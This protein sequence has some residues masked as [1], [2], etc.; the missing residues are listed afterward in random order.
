MK[1]LRPVLVV[2]IVI[3]F[4]TW[5]PSHMYDPHLSPNFKFLLST[6]CWMS[7]VLGIVLVARMIIKKIH[8]IE[9]RD[10][11]P[12]HRKASNRRQSFR[13]V[14]PE[15]MRP[16]FIVE[17]S[18]G[19]LRRQLEFPVVDLSEDGIRFIDDGSLGEVNSLIGRLRFQNGVVKKVAGNIVRRMDR[20]TCMCLQ[21]GLDWAT[22]LEEQR[23]VIR[24]LNDASN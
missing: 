7:G 3:W 12:T 10:T 6:L 5:L 22:I 13:I 15:T 21:Q 9:K 1:N 18:D 14:F 20:Q 8:H 16:T 2:L 4:A 24:K 11:I 17:T 23:M 19:Q